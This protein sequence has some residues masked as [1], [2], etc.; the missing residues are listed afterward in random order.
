MLGGG[1]IRPI[2]PGGGGSGPVAPFFVFLSLVVF[3]DL[4]IFIL[5][6]RLRS[7]HHFRA[8]L[9]LPGLRMRLISLMIGCVTVDLTATTGKMS[10]AV[11]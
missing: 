8:R 10:R 5:I 7:I 3:S 6:V 2:P 1:A 4:G 9:V 11:Q